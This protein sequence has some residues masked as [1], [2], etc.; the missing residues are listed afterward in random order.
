MNSGIEEVLLHDY[1]NVRPNSSLEN[2]TPAEIGVGSTG[3]ATGNA[4]EALS[5]GVS[6]TAVS[7][8]R[9]AVNAAEIVGRGTVGF[10]RSRPMRFAGRMMV[11]GGRRV[12]TWL[13]EE[14]SDKPR[15]Q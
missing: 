4:L 3:P 15:R 1:K 11:A 9:T 13:E 10:F 5:A 2:R 8:A 12:D 7:T 14:Q 6:T